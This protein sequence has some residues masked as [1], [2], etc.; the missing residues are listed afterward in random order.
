MKLVI[1]SIKF[2]GFQSEKTEAFIKLSGS[3]TSIIFGRNG[4]GKTTFL[5][6]INAIL[7]KD[8]SILSKEKVF[9]AEVVFVDEI[10][11]KHTIIVGMSDDASRGQGIVSSKIYDWRQFDESPLSKTTSMSMGVDR[12][13]TIQSTSIEASDIFRFLS[14]NNEVS[15]SKSMAL[16]ISEQLA[17]FLTRQSA[18]KARSIRRGKTNELQLDR[19]HAFLNNINTS[20]IES[21]LLERYRVARSYASEQIQNALFDTLAVAIDSEAEKAAALN[22]PEDLGEQIVAGKERIIEA[23]NE[24]PENKFKN[25]IIAMLSEMGA[26]GGVAANPVNPIFGQLIWNMLKE[27]KLEKQLL[28]SINIFIETF[29]YFLGEGKEIQISSEG[30]SVSINGDSLGIDSLSSGER[31]LFTFLALVVVDARNRDFLIIDEPEISLNANWQRSLIKL[32]EDLAPDT[33]IILASHSPIL[34]KGQPSSLVE[35]KPVRMSEQHEP[36]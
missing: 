36:Q 21:L 16:T 33:Q 10:D 32:L 5:K 13:T 23:L 27:L 12:G 6:L 35:L 15:L 9:R 8:E 28:D 34:A 19:D 2:I 4:S 3:Q 29:N 30:I 11:E 26:D 22:L 1:E 20:N 25:R 17:G 31:H 14:L 18:L 24:G 7:S